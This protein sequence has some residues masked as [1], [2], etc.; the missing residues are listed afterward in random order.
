M[1]PSEE[2]EY[3]K[4]VSKFDEE[5]ISTDLDVPVTTDDKLTQ[6]IQ[7]S[8][9]TEEDR[10]SQDSEKPKFQ[11]NRIVSLMSEFDVGNNNNKELWTRI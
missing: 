10:R 4:L 1:E 7:S 6:N 5:I 9:N 2:V 3:N 11:N 8:E